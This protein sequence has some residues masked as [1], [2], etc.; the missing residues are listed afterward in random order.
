MC[1]SRK[2]F[3]YSDWVV[4][5]HLEYFWYWSYQHKSKAR[6]KISDDNSIL[7]NWIY[8]DHLSK[9]TRFQFYLGGLSMQFR[10]YLVPTYNLYLT[11]TYQNASY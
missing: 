3:S 2:D 10:L 1:L 7:W 8:R 6:D 4:L 9:E 5:L 11:T